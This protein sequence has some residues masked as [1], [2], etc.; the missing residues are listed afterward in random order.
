MSIVFA[1]EKIEKHIAKLKGRFRDLEKALSASENIRDP[2]QFRELSREYGRIRNLLSALEEWE[3]FTREKQEIQEMLEQE[4][5]EELRTYM[6]EE[7]ERCEREAQ[8]QWTKVLHLLLPQD[9]HAGRN[10]VLE[11]RAG[12]GGQ[13]AA[14][15]VADLLRMYLKYAE[16][17]GWKYSI[18]DAHETGLGGYKEVVVL[19]EGKD[20]YE[21]LK[22]ESGVHRVQRIPVTESG[23]R[24]HTSAVAVVV[25]PEVEELEV[26]I[27]DDELRV[28][29]FSASG[30]GGQHVNKS[31]TGVRMTHLPTG[32]VVTCQDERSLG[33]NRRKAMRI[34]RARVYDYYKRKQEEERTEAKR[35]QVKS[36]DRSE[37]IR[38]YN[39]QQNR[40]TDHRIGLT[41]YQLE[42]VLNGN[43]DELIEALRNYELQEKLK[44][45]LN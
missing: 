25:L 30:P 20:V 33:Q 29:V 31:M 16:K 37:K 13:E 15:F 10:V 1:H 40:V 41:L 44:D 3:R 8:R 11:I 45:I 14:L 39:F 35:A 21:Y 5:E 23:G 6:K 18:T 9:K 2:H 12:T 17:K 42:D 19:F 27:K 36:G 22:Y 32:I 26:D 24:I 38:T 4:G 28:D 7:L 34:L 43:L